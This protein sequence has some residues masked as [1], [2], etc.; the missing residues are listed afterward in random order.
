[1]K[2]NRQLQE[3]LYEKLSGTWL[4]NERYFSC[5]C[6][7]D[8]HEKPALLVYNNGGW[9]A[10]CDRSFSLE[11]ISQNVSSIPVS[12]RP[13]IR[14]FRTLPKW[15]NWEKKYGDL[16]GIAKAAH[17]NILT[18]KA[19]YFKNRGLEDYI[20]KGMFGILDGWAV[21]PIFDRKHDVIDIVVRSI[22]QKGVK[23]VVRPYKTDE[24]VRPYKSDELRPLYS[25]DWL[26]VDSSRK[27]HVVYG[28]FTVWALEALGLAGVTGLTGKSLNAKSF[29]QFPDKEI[30][31]IPDYNEEHAAYKLAGQ[32]GWR[33]SVQR[34]NWDYGITDLDD[35]RRNL[36]PAKFKQLY[37]N[38]WSTA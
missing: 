28:I 22:R 23:Y 20:E 30:V 6:C 10:S 4:D 19:L 2:E 12:F 27:L 37:E 9:C 36:L 15:R 26:K 7:F 14:E 17:Q 32:L 11:Y 18:T 29:D 35:Y 31:I 5:F 21:I 33:G 3:E 24:L 25:P 16:Y 34:I 38:E 13:T 1:M 8:A